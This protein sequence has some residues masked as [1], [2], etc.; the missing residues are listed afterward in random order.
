MNITEHYFCVYKTSCSSELHKILKNQRQQVTITRNLKM[1]KKKNTP[2]EYNATTSHQRLHLK[3]A[4]RRS[5]FIKGNAL[6]QL[7]QDLGMKE[8]N[9]LVWFQNERAKYKRMRAAARSRAD[10]PAQK[11]AGVQHR[12]APIEIVPD[13]VPAPVA[14]QA[15]PPPLAVPP[16]AAPHAFPDHQ[17]FTH[18]VLP[19][20][21][22]PQFFPQGLPNPL[23]H[24]PVVHDANPIIIEDSEDEEDNV[25]AG[26]DQVDGRAHRVTFSDFQLNELDKRYKEKPNIDK[27][28]R[29]ILAIRLN[30]TQKNIK[31]YFK[32]RRAKERREERTQ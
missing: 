18:V 17:G 21:M 8:K 22:V 9:V 26:K 31:F 12:V 25:V 20:F 30:I 10:A 2:R 24:I 1:N 6:T 19:N 16:M 23:H 28:E 32:N 7:S 3:E 27:A 4:F 5:Q 15:I 11:V 13:Y 29:E 14:V